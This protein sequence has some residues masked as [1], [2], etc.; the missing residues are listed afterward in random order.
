M[1]PAQ[2]LCFVDGKTNAIAVERRP[3]KQRFPCLNKIASPCTVTLTNSATVAQT[4]CIE[5]GPAHV[6]QM[7]RNE[8]RAS[9]SGRMLRFFS[10]RPGHQ[11]LHVFLAEAKVIVLSRRCRGEMMVLTC[12]CGGAYCELLSVCRG[13][14]H[15]SHKHATCEGRTMRRRRKDGNGNVPRNGN[16]SRSRHI[17]PFLC[18]RP[19]YKTRQSVS[20]L[21]PH[22]P[23][24]IHN[25]HSALPPFLISFFFVMCLPLLP[26][27]FFFPLHT[28]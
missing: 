10:P 20:R 2:L 24:H 13:G 11:V 15:E 4:L 12:L 22:S 5:N 8:T 9:S 7:L 14:S 28:R 26:L 17:P 23:L 3:L 19:F 21:L 27:S 25:H 16:G 1:L 6:S 18:S